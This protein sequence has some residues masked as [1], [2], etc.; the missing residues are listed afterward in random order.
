MARKMFVNLP[1]RDLPRSI[2]FFTALGF[3]FNPD[4]TDDT[5]TCMIVSDENFVML[6]TRQ[7]FSYFTPRAVADAH[8]TTEV[9]VA[10]SC[11]SQ[12]EVDAMMAAALAAGG[13]EP[14]PAQDHGFMYSRAFADPD[15]HIWEP[16]FM[17]ISAIPAAHAGAA[18]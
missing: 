16:F 2:A 5:A 3:A 9:L 14:R 17:D 6:L 13:L 11:E 12:A 15:G 18:S 7:R 4:F 1:V 8:A 10:L